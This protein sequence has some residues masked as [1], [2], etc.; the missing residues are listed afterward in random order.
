MPRFLSRLPIDGYLLALIGMVVLA[1]LL[2]A[3]GQA[4]VV[5]DWVVK[6]AIALLFFL[7]GA[8]M[9]PAAIGAGLLHWRLQGT[10]FLSTFLLFPLLGLGLVFLMRGSLQPDLLTGMLY[11]CLLPSTVQ[12]SIAF[13]SIAGG[14]VAGAL[15]SA[16][17][18]N[19]LGVIVTPLLVALLIG[20]AGGGIHLQSI[21]DIGLQILAPFAV[22]QL[23]RPLLKDW[24]GRHAKLTGLVDRGSILLIVYAAFSEGVVAGV[25][26]QVA[27]MDLAK[28]IG[29]NVVLLAVVLALT[30][31][32]GRALRFDR[33]DRIVI[34]FC[35]SKKSMATGIPMAGILFASASVPLI[36]LPIMLFHQIQL[37]ACTVIAQRYARENAARR[38]DEPQIKAG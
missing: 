33:P 37:F 9:S 25:W 1:A 8:R 29:L 30:L 34:L 3:S 19:L 11:L 32:I 16:S 35:G 36:V 10:V 38:K 26:S 5:M 21:L 2:P 17:L 13:T 7:Y 24:L 23:C 27:P 14:N 12:S 15:T 4:A 6:V 18:S 31:F 22:G 20:G 28:V